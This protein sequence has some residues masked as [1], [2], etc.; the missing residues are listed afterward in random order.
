MKKVYFC[1]TVVFLVACGG[2]GG[3][4]ALADV[5]DAMFNA[6]VARVTNN[7][8]AI[9]QLQ[10]A[11]PPVGSETLV[12]AN[13]VTVGGIVGHGTGNNVQVDILLQG[14]GYTATFTPAGS[15]QPLNTYH[16][17]P[18]CSQ[19]SSHFIDRAEITV[20]FWFAWSAVASYLRAGSIGRRD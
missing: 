12:D 10:T 16:T 8:S 13:G 19:S 17:E 4:E 15:W 2:S 11:P 14:I 18:T 6:L 20:G 3:R 5:T 1:L 9:A 7:E